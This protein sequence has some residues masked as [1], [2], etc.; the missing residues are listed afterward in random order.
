MNDTDNNQ[1]YAMDD[2][3]VLTFLLQ[4]VRGLSPVST[5]DELVIDE[6]IT[7]N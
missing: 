5:T 2:Q 3:S 1:D 7:F 4:H 6:E